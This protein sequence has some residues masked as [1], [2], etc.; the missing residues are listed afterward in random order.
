MPPQ[1]SCIVFMCCP[2]C[3]VLEQQRKKLHAQTKVNYHLC[4]DL[5]EWNSIGQRLQMTSC[6]FIALPPEAQS[7]FDSWCFLLCVQTCKL[8]NHWN[9]VVCEFNPIPSAASFVL[10]INHVKHG[11]SCFQCTKS[12]FVKVFSAIEVAQHSCNASFF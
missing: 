6:A 11:H 9:Q 5:E 7:N 8:C 2:L 1:G 12:S 4:F 10:L 3:Q